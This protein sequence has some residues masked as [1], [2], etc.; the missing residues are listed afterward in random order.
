LL[1]AVHAF[2]HAQ[3]GP[4]CHFG[5]DSDIHDSILEGERSP[6]GDDQSFP[7]GLPDDPCNQNN[8]FALES[9]ENSKESPSREDLPPE[10]PL[11]TCA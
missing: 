2:G 10:P 9:A 5:L 4:V 3:R 7:E 11:I 8:A 1:A 6:H